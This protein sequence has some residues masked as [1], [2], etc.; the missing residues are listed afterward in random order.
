MNRAQRLGQEKILPLLL[1]FSI[2][3]IIGMLVQALGKPK[4]AA[5]LSLSRRVLLLIPLI[6][7]LPRFWG[8]QGVFLAYPVSDVVAAAITVWFLRREFAGLG[9]DDPDPAKEARAWESV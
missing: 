4:K 8:L 9:S 2:P 6:V 3:A 5:F 7:I 1:H